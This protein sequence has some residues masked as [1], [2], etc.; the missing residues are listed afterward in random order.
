LSAIGRWLIKPDSTPVEKCQISVRAE[1]CSSCVLVSSHQGLNVASYCVPNS[2]FALPAAG[3]RVLA[4]PT[5]LAAQGK[6]YRK[7]LC[8]KPSKRS[9]Q[10]KRMI[11]MVSW[12]ND[13]HHNQEET[14]LVDVALQQHGAFIE[15]VHVL[16]LPSVRPFDARRMDSDQDRLS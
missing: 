1:N 16:S 9:R 5:L 6:Y 12:S 15:S 10:G 2:R 11:F 13:K 14:G 8:R 7:S 4:P 3:G